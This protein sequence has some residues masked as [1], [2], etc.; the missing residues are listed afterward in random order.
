MI[1]TAR[2]GMVSIWN[3]LRRTFKEWHTDNASRLAAALSYYTAVAVAPML[4]LSIMALGW[5]FGQDSA[6]TQLVSQLRS[7]VGQ[8]GAEVAE[9]VIESA[10]RPD[11]AGIAGLFGLIT[12]IWATS[13]VFVELQNSLN[14]I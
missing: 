13:N 14:I 12:L 4:I 9:V 1:K 5:L 2:G 6:Q 3:L 7:L 11:L 10:D 8:Q